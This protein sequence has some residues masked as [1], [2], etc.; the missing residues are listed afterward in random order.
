[1]SYDLFLQPAGSKPCAAHEFAEYFADRPHYTLKHGQA[2][3]ENE[4]TGVYFSIELCEEEAGEGAWASFN[5]N[6]FRPHVFA[7]EAVPELEALVKGL[8]LAVW[9]PDSDS[10]VGR[11]EAFD[12]ERF[13]KSWSVGNEFAFRA[14]RQQGLEKPVVPSAVV[15]ATWRWNH[16]RGRLQ[17]RLGEDLFV[18]KIMFIEG[19]DGPCTASVWDDAIPCLL[20]VTDEVILYRVET[21]PRRRLKRQ[22]GLA[23][24]SWAELE[25]ILGGYEEKSALHPHRVLNY[26]H[27]P[28]KL[29]RFFR[30]QPILAEVRTGLKLDD[31]LSG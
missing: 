1:M 29:L 21:A 4:D 2:W 22:R 27:P 25:P 9:Y 6:F 30:A 3:Y 15:E 17:K 16:A 7:L 13:R 20:P 11:F 5:M 14:M 10:E 26:A 8:D 28:E 23:Q 24:V 19:E 12:A 31:I 18:P